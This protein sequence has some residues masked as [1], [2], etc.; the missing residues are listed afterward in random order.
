MEIREFSCQW[1]N[2]SE[3]LKHSEIFFL[4]SHDRSITS[5]DRSITFHGGFMKELLDYFHLYNYVDQNVS[6][7]ENLSFLTTKRQGVVGTG[8]N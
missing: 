7:Y 1:V 8:W 5:H 2:G 3:H 6:F 4:T